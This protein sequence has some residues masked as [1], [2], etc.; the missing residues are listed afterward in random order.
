MDR[1]KLKA[2]IL[3]YFDSDLTPDEERALAAQI[4][5]NKEAEDLFAE[6]MRF[7]G[8]IATVLSEAAGEK[9]ARRDLRVPRPVT[10]GTPT[11]WIL[12]AAGI[13]AAILI[14]VVMS[15]GEE[16]VRKPKPPP[17][18][19]KEEPREVLPPPPPTPPEPKPLP[20]A[21]QPIPKP[22]PKPEPPKN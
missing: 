14:A 11:T 7:N 13:A 2:D 12:V 18:V 22:E 8:N 3:R 15:G 4:R 20:P 16:P 17:L 5:G 10:A 1:D 21:P 9:Q 6:L 19:K